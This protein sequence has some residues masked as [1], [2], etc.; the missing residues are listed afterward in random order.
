VS[1]GWDF[2]NILFAGPCNRFC[3]FCIGKQVDA[4]LNENN[5]DVFPPRNWEKFVGEV[6][7]LGINEIIFTGTTT[8]PQLYRYEAELISLINETLPQ[9]RLSIHTNAALTLRKIDVF[10]LYDRAT[11]S[12][13][14]YDPV[15]YQKMMGSSVVPDLARIVKETSIPIKLSCI[16]KE[17]NEGEIDDFL[18][19]TAEIGIQRVALRKL[20]G[21]K[22]LW[23]NIACEPSREYRG[24]PIY[25]IYGIEVTLWSFDSTQ[26][27]SINLFGDGTI[28]YDYLL[29]NQ[30]GQRLIA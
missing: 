30:S 5:L 18:R 26:S 1:N 25:E 23:K 14:S 17:E 3:P 9:V 13:P 8:D 27:R 4:A 21:D 20:L 22:T 7:R 28:S 16:V 11:I 2:A 24:N 29:T 15:T 10:N 12:L 19:R 6:K